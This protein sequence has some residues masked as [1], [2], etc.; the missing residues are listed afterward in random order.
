MYI[1][2][3]QK[4]ISVINNLILQCLDTWSWCP[5]DSI[6]FTCSVSWP[7]L[8]M[9]RM[10]SLLVKINQLAVACK[11]IEFLSHILG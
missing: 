1:Y 10:K 6:L 7:H 4:G 9:L 3:Y 2:M 8:E 11:G 5:L